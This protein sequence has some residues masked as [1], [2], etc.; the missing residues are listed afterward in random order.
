MYLHLTEETENEERAALWMYEE[1]AIMAE[2][3]QADRDLIDEI[4]S[5]PLEDDGYYDGDY[6]YPER[7]EVI[8]PW[9][10]EV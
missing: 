7:P 5:D 6:G 10:V 3:E 2:Q 1:E 4:A 8:V 9:S